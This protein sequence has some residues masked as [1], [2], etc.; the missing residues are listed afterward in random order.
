MSYDLLNF[1]WDSSVENV[2]EDLPSHIT[3]LCAN[4]ICNPSLSDFIDLAVE[5]HIPFFLETVDEENNLYCITVNFRLNNQMYIR[6]AHSA[7]DAYLWS[8]LCRK[9]EKEPDLNITSYFKHLYE[10]NIQLDDINIDKRLIFT[11]EAI[12]HCKT[13][14]LKNLLQG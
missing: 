1:C 13:R 8:A 6:T 12:D 9:L 11:Q 4:H 5:N 3:Y 7:A 14:M 2:D 10:N